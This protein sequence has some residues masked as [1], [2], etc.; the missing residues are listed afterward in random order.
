[1]DL[2]ESQKGVAEAEEGIEEETGNR[3]EDAV[4]FFIFGIFAA[5]I[6]SVLIIFAFQ[7]QKE[8]KVASLDSQIKS[9]VTDQLETLT[10]E[11]KQMETVLGQLDALIT[12]L[13][14]RIKHSTLITD[15]KANQFKRSLWSSLSVGK[16]EITINGS[17]DSLEDVAKAVAALRKV[18]ALQDVELTGSTVNA[19]TQKVDF[20]VTSKVDKKLYKYITAATPTPTSGEQ[21]L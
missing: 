15:L 6:I 10:A 1:M 19:D 18:K 4:A 8:M 11:K 13:D 7:K 5:V 3:T 9:D 17:A 14:S 20:T 16:S 2:T 21:A 12:A